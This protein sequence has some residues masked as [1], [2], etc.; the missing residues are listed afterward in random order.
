MKTGKLFF[1]VDRNH[2][3]SLKPEP[4]RIRHSSTESKGNAI[5]LYINRRARLQSYFPGNQRGTHSAWDNLILPGPGWPGLTSAGSLPCCSQGV[6]P[7]PCRTCS[8][9][10][11]GRTPPSSALPSSSQKRRHPLPTLST[12]YSRQ[13]LVLS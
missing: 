6:S 4:F 3:F 5:R 8:P 12:P 9:Q 10:S 2:L 1:H 11:Q 7:F 13:P